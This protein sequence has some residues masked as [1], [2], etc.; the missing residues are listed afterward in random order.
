MKRLVIP[1]IVARHHGAMAREHEILFG[2]N[3][4]SAWLSPFHCEAARVNNQLLSV[5]PDNAE[6]SSLKTDDCNNACAK[7]PTSTQSKIG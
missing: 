5:R 6:N 4:Q 1:E 3:V 7:F 2:H